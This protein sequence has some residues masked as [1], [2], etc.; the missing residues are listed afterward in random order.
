MKPTPPVL[1]AVAL[2][3][4]L[5]GCGRSAAPPRAV[6]DPAGLERGLPDAY[7][8]AQATAAAGDPAAAD[9]ILRPLLRVRPLHVP[10]HLLHQDLARAAEAGGALAAEYA[11]LAR[12]LPSS[13]D[14]DLL[15][16]RVRGGTLEDRVPGYQAAAVKDS[17]SP[18]PRI[19]LATARTD[20][21]RELLRRAAAKEREGFAEEGKKLRADARTSAGRARTEAERGVALAP[22]LAPAHAALG[23]ALAAVVDVAADRDREKNEARVKALESFGKA[24]SID[25]G[26]PRVLLARALLL[27]D[28]G[29]REEA[30]PDL[31]AAAEALPG[32]QGILVARAR[33]LQDLGRPKEAMAGWKAA[34]AAAPRDP[35]LRLDYSYAFALNGMWKEALAEARTAER[36]YAAAGGERWKALAGI[37]TDLV[38]IGIEGADSRPLDEAR[39]RFRDYRAA[40]GPSNEWAGKMAKILESEETPPEGPEVPGGAGKAGN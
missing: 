17:G 6:P 23:Y 12:D 5:A 35:D 8:R 18:W 30:C 37:V 1:L 40:G 11:D 9:R 16:V 2:A 10:S 14:A 7:L 25:P 4:A 39:E 28:E 32:D 13:A 33:N 34:A 27:L 22:G 15:L 20:L 21:S 3:L 19:A 36:L 24:L 31:D 26:D 38:Q 29:R